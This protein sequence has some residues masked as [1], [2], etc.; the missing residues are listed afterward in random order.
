MCGEKFFNLFAWSTEETNA[1]SI[2]IVVKCN[3]KQIDVLTT[4]LPVSKGLYILSNNSEAFASELSE[5]IEEIFLDPTRI[6]L[7]LTAHV[8]QV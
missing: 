7:S 8:L 5:N 6:V 2:L 1:S 4:Q 3:N